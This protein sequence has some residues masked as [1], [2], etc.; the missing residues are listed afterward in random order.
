MSEYKI[1]D[2]FS[3][4]LDSKMSKGT[5]SI[6]RLLTFAVAFVVIFVSMM[7]LLFNLRDSIF[8]A[9]WDSLATIINA[10]MPSSED[11]VLGYIILNTITAVVGLF[12]TSTLIGVISSAIEE[13]LGELRKGNSN[14]LEK[15]HIVVLGYNNGEHGLLMPVRKRE[16]SLSLLIWKNRIWKMTCRI[17]SIFRKT[18]KYYA[19]MVT[20]RI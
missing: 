9:F 18:L 16:S 3:Y 7:I 2:K 12:F 15:D 17:M 4:W 1:K 8:S 13:K 19:G 20:S 5:I 6:I 11:G 14:V 10:E